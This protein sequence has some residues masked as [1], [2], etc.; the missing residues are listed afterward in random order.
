[1]LKLKVDFWDL[2]GSFGSCFSGNLLMT[3]YPSS[4]TYH[5]NQSAAMNVNVE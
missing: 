1:M 3:T 2:Y 5:Q 4:T